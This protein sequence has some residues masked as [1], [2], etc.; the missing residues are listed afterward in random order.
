MSRPFRRLVA[1]IGLVLMAGALSACI[2]EEPGGPHRGWCWW[3][4]Y[5][6]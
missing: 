6:C 1:A 2:I 4:P 3:H 5:R